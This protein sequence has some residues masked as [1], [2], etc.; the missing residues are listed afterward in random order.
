M[1]RPNILLILSDQMRY[2]VIGPGKEYP[3]QTPHMDAFAAQGR[4]FTRAFSPI[5]VCC[6][7]RQ[8]ML[9]GRRAETFGGNWNYG[10]GLKVGSLPPEHYNWVREMHDAGYRTGFL[11]KWSISQ[12]HGPEAFG[13]DDVNL[14]K[15]YAQ[16]RKEK[17]PDVSFPQENFFL[18]H[19]DPVDV[20]DSY[21]HYL[22]RA[23]EDYLEQYAQ[24]DAPWVMSVNFPEPHPPCQPSEPFASMY[25]PQDVPPWKSWGDTF[26]NKPYIQ[27]QQLVSWELDGMTWEDWQPVVARYY[28]IV[29]QFDQAFGRI[30]AALDRLHL[31]E[32][33]IVIYSS[34]HGDMCGGHG[35]LDKHYVLYEDN[36]HVPL[37]IRWPG[38]VQ[39]GT[40]DGFVTH[41]LDLVPTL[42]HMAGLPEVPE[43]QPDYVFHGHDMVPLLK[44]EEPDNW[45]DFAVATYNGQQFGLYTHRMYRTARWKYV[46]NLTDVDELYDLDNDPGELHNSIYEPGLHDMVQDMRKALYCELERTEDPMVVGNFWMKTQLYEGKKL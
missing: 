34:D 43:A 4:W 22:A 29:S 16:M 42:R 46:W 2:D 14:G 18:G 33:T 39:P 30:I 7:A 36:T 26:E 28:G 45:P 20:E 35:M 12:T 9:A 38:Y 3:V 8:S 17:Y 6:P 23:T 19:N 31:A 24:Q 15:A 25:A 10:L 44:G 27:K 1:P 13:F 5:P 11:G 40:S 21:T 41:S 37:G 32:N